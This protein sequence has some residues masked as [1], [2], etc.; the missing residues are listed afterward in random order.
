[1]KNIYCKFVLTIF[2]C[3]I[4]LQV[5]ATSFNEKIP[6]YL[7]LTN[8]KML[9]G[10]N[11]L[12]IELCD[13]RIK[14]WCIKPQREMGLNGQKINEYISISPDIKG[15]WRFGWSYNI[16][17][18]PEENFLPNQT[19][20]I[21]IKDYI[22]PNFISLKK[23]NISFTTLPL[24]S[25]IKEM[26]YLQ[27]N[28]DISKKFIQTRIAFNYPIDPKTLKERINFIKSSTKEKLPFSIKFNTDNT[29]AISITNIPPLT[30]KKDI[31]SIIIK[32]GVK[33]L[34]GDEIF[35]QKNVDIQNNKMQ[36]NI[37]YSYK[38]KV[39]IPSLSSYFKITNSTATIVKDAK[40]KPEQII[41]ITT[42][43]PVSG[44]E[45]KKHLELF[46]L[47]KNKP[48]FLGVTGKKNY[49][50][51]SPK[52]ITD[53][54][55]K[56]SEKINFELLPSV[57]KITTVHNFKV[58]TVA[59]RT[60]LIKIKKGIRTS[61][62]LTLGSDYTQ[63]I[64]IP[65][66]PK[67]VKLMSDGSIL[68]LSGEKKLPVYSLGIDKLY[69]EIDKIH[70]QEINHL[71]SQT[72]RYNIFQNPT[73]INEYSFNEYNISDVFQEEVIINSPNLD[74][75]HYT[76]LDFGKYF[77]SEQA[78]RY[79]KGL[80]LAKVYFKDKNNN[81]IS[82]DKRLIL[83]TNLGFIVKTDKTGTHHIFVSYISNGKP[84]EGVKVDIIGLNGEILVSSKTDSQGH[85]ILSNIHDL[86]K[87]KIP[88]AYVLTTRDDFSFMPYNRVDQQVN[89][90][91]FDIS[92]T[93][94]SNEGLKAYLFSDRGIYRPS[95]QGHIGI[96]LKQ[97]DWHGKFDGL[98]LEIQVTNPHGKVIDKNK[99]VLNSEGL[100]EY[101]FTTFDDSLTG[102]YNIS[103]YLGDQGI[104]N[105]LNS[106]SVRVGDFQP[107][108]M[109]ININFNN[110]KDTL[111]T[112]PK[113]L[114]A[115]VKLIN[116]YGIPAE[117]RK[118]RGLID[119]KPTEF[120]VTNFKEYTFYR[121][122]S[123]EE[124]FNEHLG[125]VTTDSTGTANFDVN[126]EK[127]YNATFNL[128]F[129]AEGFELDSGRS[130]TSSKSLIIS[131]L[132]YIIGFRSDSNSKYIKKQSISTIKFIA[133]SNKAEKVSAHNL[134]LK[135]NK[136]N[137]VNNLVSDANGNYSYNTVPVETN[138]SSDNVNITANEGYIY[139]VPTKEEGDYVIYLTDTKNRVFA[140]TEFSVIGEGNVTANLTD[141]AN[142]KV[143]LDKDDYKAG[144][145]ILL[146]IKTPYT[147]HGLITI[148]TDKVHNFK[149]F[150]T[151]KN[152][153]IQAI[154]IPDGFEGKGYVNV[155]F[156][157]DITATEIFMSP[158]SY[159]V[160]PFTAGVYKHKENIELILPKKIKSGK[161]LAI[162]YRTTNPC[163][164]IIFAVDEGILS[165]ADYQ[166]PDP[167][168]YF[169]NDKAL[170]VRTSQI[171][172]LILPEHRLLMKSYI[173]APSGDSL[174][175]ISRNFNP[176]KRKSQPPVKFWSGILESDLD[177]KEVTFDIPSYFNGTLRVIGVA[178]SL[179]TIGVFKADLLVQ[180]DL[181]INTNLPLFVAP[182]DEFA[183]PITIFNNLK[184]SGNAQIFLKIET[185]EGL[186]I[187]DYPKEIQ[188][189]ENNEATINVKL[190]ATDKLGS[191]N[192]KVVASINNLKHDIKSVHRTELTST[193]SVRPASPGITT[194][195]TGFITGNK[196]NLKILRNLYPKFAK[197]QIS[198]SK[199]PLSIIAGFKDF[200]D[201]YHYGCTEQLVS[202]N[203]ANVLLYNE[204]ELVQ[205]LKT[206]REK[207]DESLS[208]IFQILW[209][210]QNYD[211][212]FR[213]WNNLNDDSDPFLS[214]YTMHF[215]NEGITR[216]LAVPSDMFNE[217]LYYLEN[218]AN[219][220]IYSLD[221]AREKAYAIY[222]LTKNS[223]ITTSYI[224]NILK[225]L[226]EYHKN[227]WHDDLTSVY[228]AASYKMLKMDEDADKLLDSFT[229]NKTI[230]KTNYPYYNHLIKYSQYLYLISLH[231]PERLKN[232]DSKI[233]QDIA[234]FAKD[235]YNSLSA[236][237][238]IMATLTYAS[239]IHNVDESTIKV[240]DTDKVVTLKGDKVMTSELS[241]ES[242]EID[243]TSSSNGF[244]YQLLTSGYD[245]QLKGNKEI[246]KGIEITKKYLD[247][248]NKEVSKVKLGDNINVEI[249]MK[250]ASNKILS[251]IVIL[252]LLPG[253]FELLQDN[254][255]LILERNQ[256][257]IIW[258]PI[259]INN[260]DDRVMIFG[261]IP[262]QKMTYQYKIKA[263]NKGIF[264]TPAIYSKAMYDIQ[265][266]YRG[267]IGCIIV[268]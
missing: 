163:K 26:N 75:P 148:E 166:T 211:G 232:F 63:I 90:S 181:I 83:V 79:S 228:L 117:N 160:L 218:M 204:Q 100:G 5:I 202:Q 247:E 172:D 19:Y 241:L 125:D 88:I 104:N 242:N 127:Y 256:E 61:D 214:V 179:D 11:S 30:D 96:M 192:L 124:F 182:N 120:F 139:N 194:V 56:L 157:R 250:S 135:L 97:N 174:I 74:L 89:Y 76:N 78:G 217:G 18:I 3:L 134:T 246:V 45:V 235:N 223:V 14:E 183:V 206:D 140:Q 239:K 129:S 7:K 265:T 213:Y 28:I 266:Y 138:I 87:A 184:D 165:F 114:K 171:M 237:Y 255:N 24:L 118:I 149:W 222:I 115:T 193:T 10:K 73:F 210:R 17:F 25:M 68:S 15:E 167:I 77:Y 1:M 112:H 29:E 99:I 212:G 164:I 31:V 44:E 216:Y 55:L 23:N 188:I 105:Y 249:T 197:L 51:Q 225:Y 185:S 106:I 264:T 155:Q 203:F 8:E 142:L 102:L 169:M 65:D 85:T 21:T 180:S 9:A 200:L 103:L 20:K 154:K 122:K 86:N 156:I 205:I 93:V 92:G 220:A 94:S 16:Y 152:N 234:R 67:E 251:N 39:L 162:R 224:A 113:D 268:E 227:T 196:A 50:W 141:K 54:I 260:R 150:K 72:N 36:N 13:Y 215:L 161:K 40:L 80:F 267:S 131:P 252:D 111:W 244:F 254:N 186:K 253:G 53:D 195:D 84:A 243:L 81:I 259:Y 175:N 70:Q 208:K 123:N 137:Y 52:E 66:N 12:N 69:V 38:E 145:T 207:M 236:S 116:L 257:T 170:E 48:H 198:A 263:V 82:Q 64:Q 37:R 107:D 240:T 109:K 238:A 168:N 229:F 177:E 62:N 245:K 230:S 144:D 189:N 121:S 95:E 178:A 261:T 60:V 219:R 128:T 201:N 146:N 143:K 42:N 59:S 49:K 22:F 158:F 33:I 159:A 6:V 71:I 258:K 221:E 110:L 2:L 101:L 176:F 126:L 147:G 43:T 191:A 209:E 32:D 119:I 248:N 34:Y 187:L 130:V 226:D 98:P 132:P 173:A 233:I 35:T 262:D 190:K 199:S 91:R 136:I 27:D 4:N 58:N 47:P 57:P 41:I 153:S 231:F 46:L 108:R 133:I 151:D